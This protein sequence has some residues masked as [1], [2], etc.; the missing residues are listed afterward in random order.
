MLIVTGSLFN[1]YNKLHM[2]F[3]ILT[4]FEIWVMLNNV[5]EYTSLGNS[6]TKTYFIN[7]ET[8]LFNACLV[9]LYL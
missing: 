5:N 3:N 6:Y 9:R 1:G 2:K 8:I 4:L 7:E